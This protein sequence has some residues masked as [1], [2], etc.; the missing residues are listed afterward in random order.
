MSYVRN[1]LFFFLCFP[2]FSLGVDFTSSL[3][4]DS[5]EQAFIENLGIDIMRIA[6]ISLITRPDYIAKYADEQSL[7]IIQKHKDLCVSLQQIGDIDTLFK[8][9]NRLQYRVNKN[10]TNNLTDNICLAITEKAY[11]APITTILYTI[12]HAPIEKASKKLRYLIVEILY[13]AL[14]NNITRNAEIKELLIE[15]YG[16]DVIYAA[17]DC[18]ISRNDHIDIV[19][20]Y[21]NID[22]R[23]KSVLSIIQQQSLPIAHAKLVDLTEAIL[24]KFESHNIIDSIAQ[25]KFLRKNF[26][27]NVVELAQNIYRGRLDHKFLVSYFDPVDTQSTLIAMLNNCEYN[28]ESLAQEFDKLSQDIFQNAY[29]CDLDDSE[30][31]KEVYSALKTIRSSCDNTDFGL[32]V[33]IINHL[34]NDLQSKVYSIIY[35]N[36]TV[37]KESPE[38]LTR[39]IENFIT[40]FN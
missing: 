14:K 37:L 11:L 22:D 25:K 5:D 27:C 19:K 1:I 32:N 4:S 36:I 10:S 15:Q 8:E 21:P 6:E 13:Q 39:A 17:R 12:R 2:N 20:E 30:I 16:F 38:Q 31:K 23:L 3:I 7:K 9:R 33:R 40:R 24:K 29:L 28:Y 34:L 26:N 35:G 18:Y